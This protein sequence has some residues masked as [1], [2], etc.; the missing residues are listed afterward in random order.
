MTAAVAA[1]V[2]HKEPK[3]LYAL[4]HH[5]FSDY[6]GERVVSANYEGAANQRSNQT[7]SQVRLRL[8]PFFVEHI[9][10]VVRTSLLNETGDILFQRS[11]LSGVDCDYGRFVILAFVQ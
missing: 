6:L 8:R 3:S 9:P 5:W 4:C 7:L 2:R 11:Q 10:A 1:M